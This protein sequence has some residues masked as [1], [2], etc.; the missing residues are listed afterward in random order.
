[1]KP[2]SYI[3]AVVKG[4]LLGFGVICLGFMLYSLWSLVG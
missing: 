4:L 3:D 2:D 1:M